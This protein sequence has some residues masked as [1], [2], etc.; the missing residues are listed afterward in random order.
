MATANYTI[1]VGDPWLKVTPGGTTFFRIR[2][3]GKCNPFYL[4]I[5]DDTST[6]PAAPNVGDGY[7]CEGKDFWVNVAVAGAVWVRCWENAQNGNV[8]IDVAYV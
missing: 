1:K 8:D 7:L 2:S 3:R 4:Y 5:G 6:A